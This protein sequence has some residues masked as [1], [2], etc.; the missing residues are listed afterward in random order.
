MYKIIVVLMFVVIMLHGCKDEN[1]IKQEKSVKPNIPTVSK[2]STSG[3]SLDEQK[4][5]SFDIL[6][7]ILELIESSS[8]EAVKPQIEKSY[9]E[10]IKTC[11]DVGL[12]QEAYWKLL[13]M[14]KEENTPESLAKADAL[15][16]QFQTNYP[17]SVMQKTLSVIMAKK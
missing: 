13:V 10:L 17:D 6:S 3:L 16:A 2:K 5:K 4:I 8:R 14:Y 1:N 9:L 7:E 15:Y 11:P 12:A